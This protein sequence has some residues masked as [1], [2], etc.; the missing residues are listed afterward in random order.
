M[1]VRGS[2]H[3]YARPLMS[4]EALMMGMYP[5]QPVPVYTVEAGD[6]FFG[7][8]FVRLQE[9]PPPPPPQKKKKKKKKKISLFRPVFF[10]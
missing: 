3:N 10:F 6:F 5:M 1:Y 7:N 4:A 2:S 8:H 9:L